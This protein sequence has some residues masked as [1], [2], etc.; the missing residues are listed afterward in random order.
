[1]QKKSSPLELLALGVVL[2]LLVGIGGAII[3]VVVLRGTASSP[4]PEPISASQVQVVTSSDDE[5]AA[6]TEA[7]PTEAAP[8]E[9]APSEAAPTE[10]AAPAPAYEPRFEESDCPMR[11]MPE[12]VTIDCG[13]LIVPEN[14]SQPD[15]PQVRLAVAI[16]RSASPTPAAEPLVY[17]SGGPGGSALYGLDRWI[18]LGYT[19][20][21]DMIL[22]DQRGTGYSEPSLN[23]IEIEDWTYKDLG[24]PEWF[25]RNQTLRCSKRLRKEG[26]DMSAYNSAASAADL[27]D[28]RRALGY[29][30]L[31]LLGISY[32]TR[33]ALTTMR[34]YP[35]AVRS[36]VLD[37]T[38]PPN[39]DALTED[40]PNTNR[41]FDQ[42]FAGCAENPAC[43]ENFPLLKDRF[44]ELVNN[45]DEQP[46]ELPVINYETGRP[47][48]IEVYG[49]DML[50]VLFLSLYDTEAIPILPIVISQ[51]ADGDYFLLSQL[52]AAAFAQGSH[53]S[54]YSNADGF[55]EGMY[56]SV[57]CRE[58]MPF[59]DYKT[60]LASAADYPEL[61]N[62]VVSGYELERVMCNFWGAGEPDAIENQPVQSDIPTLVLAGQYDPITPPA[63]GKLAAESL[64]NSYFYEFPGYGHGVSVVDG[65]STDITQAFFADPAS[66]PD[67]GCLANIGAPDFLTSLDFE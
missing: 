52:F 3:A 34:D 41:A 47:F 28:L 40:A 32:G 7:A 29:E 2:L 38:Y 31:N 57:Q 18:E 63:W 27:N 8:S 14:R 36:V 24:R 37:S 33:L 16:I 64:S 15:G 12:D 50:G 20:Q 42:L 23:C 59:A 21:H 48:E 49:D 58:E 46:L 9:A 45:L 39:A 35:Q 1:M 13:T 10:A 44:Y 51:A 11:R 25:L 30:K 61:E 6:P 67:T 65:C 43:N 5:A 17:L 19:S 54:I 56:Y 22:F 62:Y 60:V 55:S 66:P 53:A 26:V 4:A